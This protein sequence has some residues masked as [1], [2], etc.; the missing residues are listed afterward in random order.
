M[1]ILNGLVDLA[2]NAVP[3]VWGRNT[4]N[5]PEQRTLGKTHGIEG[6]AVVA[7]GF[8]LSKVPRTC[9]LC[10]NDKRI[11]FMIGFSKPKAEPP[12]RLSALIASQRSPEI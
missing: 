3:C 12:H 9:G 1:S 11:G 8:M 2:L 6:S 4:R 10:S 5:N 7:S